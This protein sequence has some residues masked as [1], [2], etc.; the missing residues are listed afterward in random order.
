MFIVKFLAKSVQNIKEN[1]LI[2]RWKMLFANRYMF[3][4]GGDARG[5]GQGRLEEG[6]E[7]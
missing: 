7:G 3:V 5:G 1:V 4:Q 6:R 2:K